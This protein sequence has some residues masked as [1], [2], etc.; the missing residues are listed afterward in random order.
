VVTLDQSQLTVLVEPS[1]PSSWGPGAQVSVSG[2]YNVVLPVSALG[3][4]QLR[5]V[6]VMTIE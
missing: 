4:F 6:S 1:S 3:T 5:A 2:L